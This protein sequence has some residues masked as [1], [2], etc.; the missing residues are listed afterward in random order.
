MCISYGSYW[1]REIDQVN[2]PDPMRTLRRMRIQWGPYEMHIQRAFWNLM[3][4][5]WLSAPYPWRA[6]RRLLI[7]ND[8]MHSYPVRIL[9]NLMDKKADSVHPYPMRVL[10]SPMHRLQRQAHHS[11]GKA[12]PQRQTSHSNGK[13][14]LQRQI[15]T[16]AANLPEGKY[17]YKYL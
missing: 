15:P 13:P 3:N 7:Q 6:L 14:P 8:W 5:K 11:R 1:M 16:P 12:P 10:W 2:F 4:E 9:W 17:T